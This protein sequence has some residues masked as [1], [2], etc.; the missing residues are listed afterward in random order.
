[1]MEFTQA[2]KETNAPRDYIQ[3]P[4]VIKAMQRSSSLRTPKR[5]E[6]DDDEFHEAI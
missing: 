4:N 2:L 1:M 6:E 5:R 3:N